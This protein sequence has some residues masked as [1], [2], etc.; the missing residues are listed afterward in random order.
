MFSA[1]VDYYRAGS[2]AE[3]I[4]LLGEHDGAKLLAGGHSL[5][6]LMKLR[7][8]DLSA[9]IDIGGLSELQGIAVSNG[10]LR[11]GALTPHAEIASSQV[12]RDA[13]P[14]LA[15]AAAMIGDP[16]VRNRGTIGGNVVHADPASDLPTVLAALGATFNVT[17]PRGEAHTPGPAQ[18][19][20]Q[21]VLREG[22]DEAEGCPGEAHRR[23]L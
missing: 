21:Q 9:L 12:V 3:A 19:R 14:I 13:C 11:I 4:S 20:Y 1:N 23:T 7:L 15:E 17:G 22:A 18:R 16:Q 5:I 2:V 8:T 10:T 6:P